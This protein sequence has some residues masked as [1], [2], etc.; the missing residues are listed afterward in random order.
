MKNI[1]FLFFL[2]AI[3]T[4]QS[5]ASTA[6]SF[7]AETAYIVSGTVASDHAGYTGTGFVDYFNQTGGYIEWTVNAACAGTY[8]MDFRY[9]NATAGNRPLEIRINGTIVNSRLAFIGTGAWTTWLNQGLNAQLN[10]GTNTIRATATTM[11][12]GPNIDKLVIGSAPLTGTD[13]GKA[14]VDSTM[15]RYRS[16]EHTSELQSLRHLVCRL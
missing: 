10:A 16:E 12:G 2:L 6:L 4:H 5:E 15:A 9:A 11:T 7:Q 14:V 8:H 13:W 1:L 3:S